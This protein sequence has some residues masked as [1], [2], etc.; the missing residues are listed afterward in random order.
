MP[1]V[2][3]PSRIVSDGPECLFLPRR[4]GPR[5]LPQGHCFCVLRDTHYSRSQEHFSPRDSPSLSPYSGL[6]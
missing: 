2:E 1:W 5:I 6:Q 4:P 3:T